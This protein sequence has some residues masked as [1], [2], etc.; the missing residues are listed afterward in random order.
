METVK[1]GIEPGITMMLTA[2]VRTTVVLSLS[3]TVTDNVVRP[4]PPEMG[5]N[6]MALTEVDIETTP[7]FE[8]CTENGSDRSSIS[9]V[10]IVILKGA[11]PPIIEMLS[12]EMDNVGVS[13]TD[14]IEMTTCVETT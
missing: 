13:F 1:I 7:G 4:N 3:T 8:T 11:K 2:I 9:E 12:V 10:A 14:R 5:D 6:K